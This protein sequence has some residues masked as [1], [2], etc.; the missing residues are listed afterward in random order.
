MQ[1]T[2]SFGKREPGVNSQTPVPYTLFDVS[3]YTL[4][5]KSQS[6]Q[7]PQTLILIFS[8]KTDHCCHLSLASMFCR[9]E[10]ASRQK[11]KANKGVT[12]CF[13]SLQNHKV[14]LPGIHCLKTVALFFFSFVTVN[15]VYVSISHSITEYSIAGLGFFWFVFLFLSF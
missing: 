7:Q 12:W 15:S 8:T 2:Q 11:A 14:I 10:T 9:W 4:L 6:S 13:L 1:L 3:F 5:C